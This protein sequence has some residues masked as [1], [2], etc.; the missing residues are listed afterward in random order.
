[1]LESSF[2]FIDL[3]SCRDNLTGKLIGL[4]NHPLTLHTINEFLLPAIQPSNGCHPE[5]SNKDNAPETEIQETT[6]H[7]TAIPNWDHDRC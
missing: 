5:R 2:S 3:A 1:M 4:Q 6:H 7:N